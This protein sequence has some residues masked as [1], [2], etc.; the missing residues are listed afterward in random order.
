MPSYDSSLEQA[1]LDALTPDLEAQ[2]FQVFVHPQRSILPPFM[3][4]FQPDAIA[5]KADKKIAIEVTSKS[6]RAN[7]KVLR[8][9]NL[10]FGHPDW[11]L[12]VLYAP[13]RNSET[14]FAKPSRKT[15]EAILSGLTKAVEYLGPVPALVIA[16]AAFEAAARLLVPLKIER[17]QTPARLVET[18]ASDGYITP[19]EAD[20]SRNLAH[21]RNRAPM[22]IFMSML[23]PLNWKSLSVWCRRSCHSRLSGGL[24][25]TSDC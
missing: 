20:M 3:Q 23:Q 21:S 22:A 13:A 5:V 9:Q 2:G 10:F 17:P 8:L 16:W 15:I 12:K 4:T 18:L 24:P 14:S 11:E 19:K 1:V 6:P 7:A 25:R